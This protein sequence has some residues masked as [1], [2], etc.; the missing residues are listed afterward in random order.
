[1]ETLIAFV[2]SQMIMVHGVPIEAC[3]DHICIGH[4]SVVVRSQKECCDHVSIG[5]EGYY[6]VGDHM[7][8]Y[9]EDKPLKKGM[10]IM[11]WKY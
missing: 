6:Y 5:P 10:K 3:Q 2:G 9:Y 8:I 7:T 11:V 1:M 4:G